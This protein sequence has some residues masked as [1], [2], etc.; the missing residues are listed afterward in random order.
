MARVCAAHAR[1]R[2]GSLAA[3][4]RRLRAQGTKLNSKGVAVPQHN[5]LYS[6][7]SSRYG[8]DG[9]GQTCTLTVV[10]VVYKGAAHSVAA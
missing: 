4:A 7:S 6:I 9:T 8:D 1:A 3:R 10:R 2:A 5:R